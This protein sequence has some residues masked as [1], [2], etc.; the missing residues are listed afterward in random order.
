VQL[1]TFAKSG[2]G[3]W[4]DEPDAAFQRLRR[5]ILEEQA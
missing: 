1:A 2:H 4:R 5:F 3:A